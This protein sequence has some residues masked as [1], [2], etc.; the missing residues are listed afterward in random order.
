MNQTRQHLGLPATKNSF[1]APVD[2]GGPYLILASPAVVG[3]PSDWPTQIQL[4]G[5][6][7]WDQVSSWPEP[8]GLTD[9]LSGDDRPI[10]VTLGASSSIDPQGFYE[11]AV[12]AV[13]E[14]GHR[15][16]VLT[17]P[18]PT[19]IQGPNSD[20]QFIVPFAPLSV[21]ATRCRAAIHHA[22]IGTT[23][24]LLQAGIP[25][26]LIPRVH[27]Q[28]Q[29]A[30]RVTKLGVARTLPWQKASSRRL[31]REVAALLSD[32]RYRQRAATLQATLA[33]EDGLARSVDAV[34]EALT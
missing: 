22:G 2:C 27:D 17:G 11:H 16:L 5:F 12:D 26:L 30:I 31:R 33:E 21:V 6:V 18:T 10:L 24:E 20:R 34:N 9:F 14:L 25:Q 15:A 7:S 13:A 8:E 29:T 1:F 32:Q 3:R 4:T 19:P 28:P 23:V